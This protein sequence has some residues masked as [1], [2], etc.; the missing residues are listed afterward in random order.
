MIS[1][2]TSS[3]NIVISRGTKCAS[4]YTKHVLELKSSMFTVIN[5][6]PRMPDEDRVEPAVATISRIKATTSPLRP[7]FQNTRSFLAKSLHWEPLVTLTKCWFSIGLLAHVRLTCCKQDRIVRKP[8][9]PSPGLKFIRIITFPF[10]QFFLPV[11]FVYMVI[12][13]LKTES[14]TIN[15]KPH[16]KVTK[17]KS[18]FYLFS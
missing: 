2:S 13:K 6:P 1:C 17:L 18:K 11:C 12:I 4:F 8:V 16:C 15:R 10:I 7:V 14:S 9:N 5:L 3:N